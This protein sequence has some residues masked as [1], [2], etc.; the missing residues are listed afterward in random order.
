M[1]LINMFIRQFCGDMGELVNS[2][3]CET[4]IST[5][6]E[7]VYHP[8]KYK[9]K[10]HELEIRPTHG[11]IRYEDFLKFLQRNPA[12]HKE[13]LSWTHG[14]KVVDGW[15]RPLIVYHGSNEY[16][17]EFYPYT[18]FGTFKTSAGFVNGNDADSLQKMGAYFLNIKNP[19]RINDFG[20]HSLAGYIRELVR[21]RVISK[22]E[23]L[24]I[25]KN[26]IALYNATDIPIDNNDLI[27]YAKIILADKH[28]DAEFE[29]KSINAWLETI[30]NLSMLST[31]SKIDYDM[32]DALTPILVS[33]NID[34]FSYVNK[35]E[36]SSRSI[37]WIIID[38]KQVAPV[39]KFIRL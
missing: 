16:R 6:A 35:H 32:L 3:V 12:K 33:K 30:D 25:L 24:T 13:F 10:L 29:N 18:H 1:Y 20:I 23:V 22:N 31:M 2:M 36:G 34:G 27:S 21:K 11:R 17:T 9:M 37:S 19:L 5:G 26:S 39:G 38:P 4:I 7:P 14:T 8:N 15:D 28:V